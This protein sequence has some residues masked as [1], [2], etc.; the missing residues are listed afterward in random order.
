MEPLYHYC[1]TETFHSIVK[2]RSIWLSSLTQSNDSKEGAVILEILIELA[3]EA[4]L[5]LAAQGRLESALRGGFD[6]FDGLGFCLSEEGD[7]LSQ[8]RGYAN[9]GT[10]VSIGFNREYLVA[11]GA[12]LRESE[13]RS[14][15]LKKLIYDRDG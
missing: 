14:F 12:K 9:D 8:W 6:F 7:L 1:S 2:N 15:G 5:T 4:D 10:G 11:L 3:N 13:G